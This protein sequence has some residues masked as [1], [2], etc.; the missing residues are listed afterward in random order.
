M[1]YIRNYYGVPAKRGGRVTYQGNP[2]TITGHS[3][4]HLKV[5]LD[6]EKHSGIYH[7][8]DLEYLP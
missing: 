1:D 7:P 5:R 8:M 2:G 6:G 3:G 4:P